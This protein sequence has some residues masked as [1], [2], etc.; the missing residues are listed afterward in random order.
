MSPGHTSLFYYYALVWL[1]SHCSASPHSS[2][3][4]VQLQHAHVLSIVPY[5]EENEEQLQQI[6]WA[7]LVQHWQILFLKVFGVSRSQ[8]AVNALVKCCIIDFWMIKCYVSQC[9]LIFVA[10][11]CLFRPLFRSFLKP[12]NHLLPKS[13]MLEGLEETGAELYTGTCMKS[14]FLKTRVSDQFVC[15]KFHAVWI[16]K[17]VKAHLDFQAVATGFDKLIALDWY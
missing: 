9:L 13:S 7:I 4:R 14:S 11:F 5:L 6:L 3:K 1:L 12:G 17:H 2:E 8:H 16:R 15:W 10:H